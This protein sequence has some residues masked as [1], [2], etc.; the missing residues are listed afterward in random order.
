MCL[1]TRRLA[2]GWQG[3]GPL[4]MAIPR[5]GNDDDETRASPWSLPYR[6]TTTAGGQGSRIKGWYHLYFRKR[7]KQSSLSP[8]PTL[9]SFSGPGRRST[10]CNCFAGAFKD[11]L[12]WDQNGTGWER[13]DPARQK[14]SA[15]VWATVALAK[16]ELLMLAENA[17]YRLTYSLKKKADK[18]YLEENEKGKTLDYGLFLRWW[19]TRKLWKKSIPP[20]FLIT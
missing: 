2:G 4:I 5:S 12:E 3:G 18:T 6:P 16:K 19:L 20:T 9:G 11:L 7:F 14:F 1:S 17:K 8:P 15:P 13:A 10:S